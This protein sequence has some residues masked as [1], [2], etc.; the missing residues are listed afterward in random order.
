VTAQLAATPR[1]DGFWMPAELEPHDGTWLLW[2]ERSDNWRHGATPAQVSYAR[3]AAAIAAAEPVTIGVSASQW[4][5]CRS[6]V[7]DHVRVIEMSNDDAWVRDCGPTFVVDDH[8]GRRAVDW[9]FNAWGGLVD[10]LY[11]P[12]ALDD[13]VAAKIAEVEGAD[14]YRAPIVLEGGS[15]HS[16]GRGTLYTTEECLLSAGRNPEL[17]KAQIEAH[18][19]SYTG[20]ERVIWLGRG[21]YLDET[22][23]HVDN[24][25][26]VAG[27]GHVLLHWCDDPSDPQHEIS[28]DARI[29]LD[30]M[31]D[32]GGRSIEVTLLPAPG[33]ICI[34]E[35]EAA[36]VDTRA[37]TLPR[38][39]GDRLAGSY[40]NSYLCN[41]RVIVPLLDDRYDDEALET[42]AKVFVDREVVGVPAREVLLGG[43]NLHCI[44]QQVPSPRG[45]P[46]PKEP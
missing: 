8:G 40:A 33:P 4:E 32:A 28:L 44:T 2:P 22:N 38:R 18:L 26:C 42:Y 17:A 15:I 41:G 13:Q 20:A 36:D 5:H 30:S 14:R 25:I 16:D 29:R 24:L 31:V 3:V 23:G 7:P 37:G 45:A 35:E 9:R 34:T 1:D 46:R 43:G 21:V 39:P 10:G 12:W 11:F 6:S 27:P 19:R